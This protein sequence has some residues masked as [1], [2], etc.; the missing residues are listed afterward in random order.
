MPNDPLEPKKTAQP[1][2]VD[3]PSLDP[4]DSDLER[5]HHLGQT[6]EHAYPA[7]LEDE[8]QSGG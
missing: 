8:N 3:E 2:D 1:E 6:T 5:D 7:R 4:N